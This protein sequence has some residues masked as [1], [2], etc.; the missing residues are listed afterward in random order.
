VQE[1]EITNTLKLSDVSLIPNQGRILSL[2]L[3]TK[4]VGFA[5]CDESQIAIRPH[6]VVQRIN[7]KDF[8]KKT[9]AIIEEL[10]AKILVIGLPYNMDDSESSFA[11]EVRRIA[12]NFSL[13]LKIPVFLQD[14]RLTSMYA[15]R[16]L[17]AQGFSQKEML[18][19]IDSEAAA[20]ILRDFL[21]LK[22]QLQSESSNLNI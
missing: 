16:H 2:D 22:S 1:V 9:I 13:S 8:L 19:R 5:V 7:W 15:E 21:E 12:R 4:K 18:Q 11:P 14:E 17:K 10:D 6:S 3:G 20:I